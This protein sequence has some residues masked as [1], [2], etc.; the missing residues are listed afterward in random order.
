MVDGADYGEGAGHLRFEQLEAGEAADA[1]V[2]DEAGGVAAEQLLAIP[3]QRVGEAVDG[4]GTAGAAEHDEPAGTV[5]G[6]AAPAEELEEDDTWPSPRRQ[7]AIAVRILCVLIVVVLLGHRL[8]PDVMGVGSLIDTFLPWTFVPLLVMVPAALASRSRWAIGVAALSCGAWA[9]DFG[10]R[11][12]ASGGSGPADLRILSQNVS[13]KNPDLTGIG[14][15]AL[16]RRADLVVLQGM[17]AADLQNADSVVPQ[18]YPY[19]LAMYE[20]AVWSRYPIG[21]SR[22]MELAGGSVDPAGTMLSP[23]GAAL[24]SGLFGGL[25][26]FTVRLDPA[27]SAT[28]Y[29]VHLPQPSLSHRGFGLARGDALDALSAALKRESDKNL[30]VVGDLDLAQTDRGMSDLVGDGTGLVSA[31]AEA[32]R[33][34]GFTWPAGFPLIRLDDVLTRGLSP[35]RSTV[36]GAVGPGSAHRPI[37]VDLR[38]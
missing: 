31:Q 29:A 36:L 12:V 20:F 25:L 27:R 7:I 1:E 18:G 2:S 30:I 19:H 8:I 9:A 21:A 35:V 38:F 26:Q 24:D 34:F 15:L 5:A 32:G 28:V 6:R 16:D 3:A 17:S 11:L 22:P 23:A 10:P 37:E 14:R 4:V 13:S 33:G